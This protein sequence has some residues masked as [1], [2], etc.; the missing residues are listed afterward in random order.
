M[1]SYTA[2]KSRESRESQLWEFRESHLGVLR[3][4]VIMMWA[5]WR[6]I[7]YIIRGKVVVSPKSGPW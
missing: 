6:D 5:L 2:P 7:E 4:N 1:Q 3:Q